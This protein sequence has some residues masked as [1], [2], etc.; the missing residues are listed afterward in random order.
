MTRRFTLFAMVLLFS[1]NVLAVTELFCTGPVSHDDKVMGDGHY[2]VVIADDKSR[3]EIYEG[4]KERAIM[5]GELSSDRLFLHDF[6]MGDYQAI[7]RRFELSRVTL[8]FVIGFTM[9]NGTYVH[10]EG[11]CSRYEAKL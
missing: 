7:I 11:S 8:G 5:A 10:A 4:M 9:R 2:L 6:L 1:G 3:Y